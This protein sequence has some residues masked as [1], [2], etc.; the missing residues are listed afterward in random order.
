[1][2]SLYQWKGAGWRDLPA[3]RIDLGGEYEEPLTIQ[4]AGELDRLK[5]TLLRNMWRAPAPWSVLNTLSW[6]K[7]HVVVDALPVLP[8]LHDG[9][10]P[11]L[12]L[13]KVRDNLPFGAS[14]IVLRLWDSNVRLMTVSG[15]PRQLWIGEAVAESVSRPMSLISIARTMRKFDAPLTVF[16]GSMEPDTFVMRRRKAATSGWNGQVVLGPLDRTPHAAE[17]GK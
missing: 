3:R 13:I 8:K 16:T 15:T 4:W 5:D 7:P 12:T 9:R 2:I 1:M 17:P 14:R 11:A 10:L 6:L